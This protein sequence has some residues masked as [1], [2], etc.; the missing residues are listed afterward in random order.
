MKTILFVSLLSIV[1]A[2]RSV[3]SYPSAPKPSTSPY[4][5]TKIG[6]WGLPKDKKEVKEVKRTVKAEPKEK[7]VLPWGVHSVHE[8]EDLM[9]GLE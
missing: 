7:A 2:R 8:L 9:D 1:A 3:P 5:P 4:G 6:T